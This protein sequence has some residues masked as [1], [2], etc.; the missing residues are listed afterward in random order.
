M[1]VQPRFL[2]GSRLCNETAS[3]SGYNNSKNLNGFIFLTASK[4]RIILINYLHLIF[5]SVNCLGISRPLKQLFST[6]FVRKIFCKLSSYY[7][8][9]FFL[10]KFQ[11]LNMLLCTRL[12]KLAWSMKIIPWE[13]YC[14]RHSNNIWSTKAS[15][16]KFLM[17]IHYKWKLQVLFR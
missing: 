14:F 17:E 13:A 4:D 1:K 3:S 2:T 12:E 11:S 9:R 6:I 10:V 16:Q 8:R 5:W 7:L 15:L